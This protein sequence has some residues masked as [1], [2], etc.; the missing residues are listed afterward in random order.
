MEV[1][2]SVRQIDKSELYCGHNANIFDLVLL[3]KFNTSFENL[4]RSYYL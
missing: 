1:S 3:A 4:L 2:K